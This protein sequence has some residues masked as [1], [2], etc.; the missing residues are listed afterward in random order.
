MSHQ[1][2]PTHGHNHSHGHAHAP[3]HYNRSF[4]IGVAL[5]LGFVVIEALYG[6]WAGSLALLADAGHNLSDVLGLLLAWGASVLAR[7]H[8]SRLRTFGLKKTTILAALLNAVL[9]LIA[10]GA[11][12][13]EA[14]QRFSDPAPVAGMTVMAVAAIGT[15][16]N[17]ATMLLFMGGQH[18][19]NIRGAF[20]HMAADAGVS[21]GVV[22]AGG[23]ILL[24]GISWIDPLVSLVIA[25][26]ILVGTWSLLT[27]SLNLAVDAV[28]RNIDLREVEAALQQL[29]DVLDVHHLHVWALSTTETALTAHLVRPPEAD[30]DAL[31][32]RASERLQQD[33]GI[34]HTTLQLEYQ[35]HH[36]PTDDHC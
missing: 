34:G 17:A 35:P 23:L 16:I 26:V 6:F 7:R 36:C 12:A 13:W 33:F 14:V 29:P 22:V 32:H 25:A 28:P 1:H 30:D 4:A 9:L 19:L 31:I 20:L 27:E 2:S 10:I 18:D 8:S 15:L 11:I 24:T 21:L 5:N 3:A